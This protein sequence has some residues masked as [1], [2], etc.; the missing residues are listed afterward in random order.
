MNASILPAYWQRPGKSRDD[1]Q[2]IFMR[3]TWWILF[4]VL[5]FPVPAL[6]Q[7]AMLFQPGTMSA[8]GVIEFQTHEMDFPSPAGDATVETFRFSPEFGYF[9]RSYLAFVGRV[10]YES[11][12]GDAVERHVFSIGGG[13]RLVQPLAVLHLYAGAEAG[14]FFTSYEAS[15]EDTL[16]FGVIFPLGMLIPLSSSVALDVGARI[17]RIWRDNDHPAASNYDSF[18]LD[19]GYLGVQAFF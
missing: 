13:F 11:I 3:R 15:D 9:F 7:S 1:G 19:V 2:E 6:A 12:S 14:V 8:G 4:A 18:I 5:L 10:G 17:T 16:D